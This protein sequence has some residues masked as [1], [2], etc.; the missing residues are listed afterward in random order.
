MNLLPAK[1]RTELPSLYG[2]QDEQDPLAR[3]KLFTPWTYW[4]WYITEF[5][6]QDRCFGLVFGH[7]REWGYFLLSE[8]EQL[9]GPGGLR[10]ERDLHFTP[11]RASE[12]KK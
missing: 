10:V 7:E 12:L 4:T 2:T 3:V 1:L 8:L 5:D 11:T 6:G 9:C